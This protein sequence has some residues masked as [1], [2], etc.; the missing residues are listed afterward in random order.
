[1]TNRDLADYLDYLSHTIARYIVS[2]P[3][4]TIFHVPV[5]ARIYESF[6]A[7]LLQISVATL[8]DTLQ[9]Y[10]GIQQRYRVCYEPRIKEVWVALVPG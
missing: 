5:P 6:D 4:D 2:F 3:E 10:H 8:A 1:M 9:R 7:D